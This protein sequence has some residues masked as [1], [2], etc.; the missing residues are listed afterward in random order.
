MTK[1][2]NIFMNHSEASNRIKDKILPIFSSL[3][4]D[5]SRIYRQ[6]AEYNFVIGGDG[7][8]LHAVHNSY[9]SNIP[10]VGINTGHLGFYQEIDANNIDCYMQ[11]LFNHEYLTDTL[12]LLECTVETDAWTYTLKAVNEFVIKPVDPH[13]LHMEVS[14]DRISLIDQVGDGI[15]F[16]TPAGSTAYNLSAGGSI[17]YQTLKGYQIRAISPIK[18]K[19]YNSLPSSIVVPSTSVC[20]LKFDINDANRIMIVNDGIVNKYRGIRRI[21]LSSPEETI[22]RIVFDKDLYWRNLKDKFL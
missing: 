5:I 2:I 6:D 17:L 15:I 22:Q 18:S 8:F 14:F 1:L 12:S 7:T 20:E 13:L 21:T 9:F 19:R 16:S 4:Y 3:G 11:R 10:F